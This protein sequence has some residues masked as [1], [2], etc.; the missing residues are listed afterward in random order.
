MIPFN[1]PHLTGKE[2]PNIQDAVATGKLSGNGKYTQLCHRY[3][4]ERYG[5]RHCLLTHSCTGAL[6]MAALL[7]DIREG[8]EVIMPAFTFVSTSNAFVLRGARIVFADSRPD[9]PNMD[10][11]SLE[12]LITD[13]TRAIVVVH[14]GGAAVDMRAVM[15]LAEKHGLL[16]VEDAAQAIDA[17]FKPEG[18]RAAPLGGIGHLAAF[19]FHETKNIIAGEGGMLVVN[20]ERF[21]ARSEIIWEKG[22][23]RSAFFRGQIDKYGWVDVGSS[24]LPSEVTAAFLYAQL[25]ELEGIQARRIAIWQAYDERLSALQHRGWF[26]T[27]TLPAAATNNAHVY[28][29]LCR[30]LETRTRLIQGL[31]EAGIMAVFHYQGLHRSPFYA[32]RHDGRLLPHCDAYSDRLVRLPL[33]ADLSLQEVERICATIEQLMG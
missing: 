4:Q 28:Y 15:A 3:F 14:Y 21:V 16:V 2:L 8:D 10:E 12:H 5:F 30:D 17:W 19:S 11:S 6:E 27:P 25:M 13:R 29:L 1:R 7:L 18:A 23:N 24:F 32:D 33:F 31:K 9:H 26:T 20:D 22:T